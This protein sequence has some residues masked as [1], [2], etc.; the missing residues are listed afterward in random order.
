VRSNTWYDLLVVVNGLVVT[1]SINGSQ[2]LT[3]QYDPRYIDGKAYGLNMGYVGVGSNNSQGSFDNV[4][5]QELPPASTFANNEDYSDGVADLFTGD[6]SGTWTV[7]SGRYAGSATASAPAVSVLRTPV[8]VTADAYVELESQITVNGVAGLVFDYYSDDDYKYA[9]LDTST[10]K[11]TIGHHKRKRDVADLITTVTIP[12]G[13]DQRFELTLRGLTVN[14]L[15]NGI[16][17]AT[18]SYNGDVVD[19]GLGLIARTG[20]ASYD[21]TRVMVGTQVVNAV[22]AIAPTLTVP[23]NVSRGNDAGKTTAFVSDSTIGTATAT[24]NVPGVTVTRAGV[25]AGNIFPLGVTTITWTA[26]DV[27]GNQT[28]K[29]Q[30][31]TVTDAVKPTISVPANVNLSIPASQSSVVVTNAQLGTATASDNSGVVTLTRSGVPAGNVFG[32]GTTTI[33]YTAVDAAGNTTVATQ[34]VTVLYPALGLAIAGSQSATEGASTT[35]NLGTA[36]G[37]GGS[38][39]VTVNWGDGQSSTLATA[40]VAMTATHV[41]RDNGYYTVGVTL[42]DADGQTRA[43]SFGVSVANAAPVV[44]INTPGP[45]SNLARNT[46]YAFKASFTDA[47]TADTHTCSITWGDGYYS[48]GTVSES[49]GTCLSNHTYK[50]VGSYTITVTVTDNAGASSTATSAITVTT[51]GGTVYTLL[52]VKKKHAAKPAKKPVATRHA[53]AQ[54]LVRAV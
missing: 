24:D 38:W 46:S 42:T 10:G 2:R 8:S 1:V 53:V 41:Y 45:G 47:G 48:A 16:T 34:T 51:S 36:S 25:P 21:N 12:A 6:K 33:T 14:A 37:G 40:P 39:S 22:D 19:G 54:F 30:T 4:G 3:F 50:T 7:S 11:L 27:F 44:R 28:V 31:V 52:A 29:T 15:L 13:V 23:G 5:V 32:P 35:F 20:T 43:G 49:A 9:T 17:V 18:F 26:L